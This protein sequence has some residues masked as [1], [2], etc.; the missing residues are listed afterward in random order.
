MNEE[1]K[2]CPFCGGD[3]DEPEVEQIEYESYVAQIDCTNCDISVIT[4]Y[5]ESSEEDAIASLIA[6]WNRRP[7]IGEKT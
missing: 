6:S 7:A 5:G 3:P 1:L 2:P 4:Q